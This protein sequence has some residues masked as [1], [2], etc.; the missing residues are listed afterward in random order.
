MESKEER[1]E[2]VERE[3]ERDVKD[4]RKRTTYKNCVCVCCFVPF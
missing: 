1:N 3:R 4:I 2:M